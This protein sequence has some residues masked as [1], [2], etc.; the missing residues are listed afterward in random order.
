MLFSRPIWF[1]SAQALFS[2]DAVL[3][4][5]HSCQASRT[6]KAFFVSFYLDSFYLVMFRDLLKHRRIFL[7]H[8]YVAQLLYFRH[9]SWMCCA[10]MDPQKI[11]KGKDMSCAWFGLTYFGSLLDSFIVLYCIV[12]GWMKSLFR[13]Y[14]TIHTGQNALR[15]T[16]PVGCGFWLLTSGRS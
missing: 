8:G 6:R 15:W 3:G 16:E 1:S 10:V 13:Y 7:F 12:L 9:W 11:R 5:K 14:W 2:S 4:P